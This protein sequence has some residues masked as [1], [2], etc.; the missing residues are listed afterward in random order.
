MLVISYQTNVN[1]S[2]VP[3]CPVAGSKGTEDDMWVRFLEFDPVSGR[4]P[5]QPRAA[6]PGGVL[7]VLRHIA[8]KQTCSHHSIYISKEQEPCGISGLHPSNTARV[9]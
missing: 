7:S 3:V 5:T 9:P 6:S 2:S 1:L 8:S 4:R